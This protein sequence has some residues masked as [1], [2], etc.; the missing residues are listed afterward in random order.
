MDADA[1]VD[2]DA[3]AVAVVVVPDV[4]TAEVM[5]GVCTAAGAVEASVDQTVH[6]SRTILP[7]TAADSRSTWA[8]LN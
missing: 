5:L 2:A 7:R 4:P 3:D 1:D 6:G 8:L